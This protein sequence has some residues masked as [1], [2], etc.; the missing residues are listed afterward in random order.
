MLVSIRRKARVAH[1][2]STGCFGEDSGERT[3][4]MQNSHKDE[5]AFQR[6]NFSEVRF[7]GALK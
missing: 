7:E 1:L 6:F 4:F 2:P 5:Q 3:I